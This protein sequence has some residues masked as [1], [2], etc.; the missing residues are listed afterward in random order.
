MA[1]PLRIQ[2][3][4]AYYHVTARGVGRGV[5]YF[6]GTDYEQFVVLLG[7]AH[8]RSELRRQSAQIK[9]QRSNLVRMRTLEEVSDDEFQAV[10]SELREREDNL[11]VQIE[12]PGKRQPDGHLALKVFELSQTL[13]DAKLVPTIRKPFDILAEGPLVQQTRDPRN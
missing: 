10:R 4:G 2:F 13:V 3:R 12:N 11:V 6:D 7:R 8:G 1:R 9:K 5:I